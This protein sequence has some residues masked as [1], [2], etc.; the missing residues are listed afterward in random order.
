L[1]RFTLKNVYVSDYDLRSVLEYRAQSF[2]GIPS[3][4]H[5]FDI[6]LVFE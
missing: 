5:H 6:R 4:R 3:F 1:I 2:G